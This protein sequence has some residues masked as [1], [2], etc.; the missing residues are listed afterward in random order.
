[1]HLLRGSARSANGVLPHGHVFRSLGENGQG[2]LP[3]MDGG[4]THFSKNECL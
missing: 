4:E 1:M 2:I 3:E